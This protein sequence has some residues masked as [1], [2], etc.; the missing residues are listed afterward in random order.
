MINLA[1]SAGLLKYAFFMVY[2]TISPYYPLTV[3][4]FRIVLTFQSAYIGHSA[5][6]TSHK[7]SIPKAYT[8]KAFF[9]FVIRTNDTSIY[10]SFFGD[11]W[12]C[13]KRRGISAFSDPFTFLLIA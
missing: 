10:L 12:H 13:N 3:S 11:I 8:R 9:H 6:M 5:C 4:I 2:L 7:A 1:K